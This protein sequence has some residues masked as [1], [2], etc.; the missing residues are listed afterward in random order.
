MAAIAEG[1]KGLTDRVALV[2]GAGSGLGRGCAVEL[3][4][5]GARVVCVGRRR[6]PLESLVE[7]LSGE[8]VAARA[9]AADLTDETQVN[10][11]IDVATGIGEL[12]V[13][14]NA[15]G[16]SAPGMA[17]SYS[18]ADWDAS[19][20]INVRGTFC[21]CQTAGAAML[22]QG[23]GGSIVNFS[24]VLG[25]IGAPGNVSYVASKHAVEGLT[26]ALAVEWA[27][28]GVRVNA[29]APGFV[30]TPLVSDFLSDPDNFGLVMARTPLARTIEVEEVARAV[31][32]LAS[33]AA[34]AVTGS[35]LR[36]DGGWTAC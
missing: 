28:T 24:S 5:A 3:G 25:S 13:V 10:A 7:Q 21:V 22:E 32:Y 35:I 33:D 1:E 30:D 29:V 11:A 31:A 9:F 15:A 34:A 12:G 26:K 27:T 20:A 18:L 14:V 4:R 17:N 6:E 19:F 2:T 16:I 23:K 36:I 8:G